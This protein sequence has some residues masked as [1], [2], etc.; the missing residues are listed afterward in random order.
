MTIIWRL[1]GK[2]EPINKNSKFKD[3]TNKNRYSYKAVMWAH[4]NGITT[5]T[6]GKFYPTGQCKRREIVTFIYRYKN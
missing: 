6:D 2:P 3:V 5:G 1:A 4:E